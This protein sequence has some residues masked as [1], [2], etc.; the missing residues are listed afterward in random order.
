[1]QTE[2]LLCNS[3]V[4]MCVPIEDTLKTDHIA[5]ISGILMKLFEHYTFGIEK[6][7]N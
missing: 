6:L 3:P 7:L 4:S 2:L 5:T 1:M